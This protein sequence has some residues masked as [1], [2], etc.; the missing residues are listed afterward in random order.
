M[1]FDSFVRGI[2]GESNSSRPVTPWLYRKGHWPK[3]IIDNKRFISGHFPFANIFQELPHAHFLTFLRDPLEQVV[4]HYWQARRKITSDE[5]RAVKDVP[6]LVESN[7]SSTLEEI[8]VKQCAGEQSYIDNMQTRFLG[9]RHGIHSVEPYIAEDW[10]K[11]LQLA[12][13]RLANQF[14]FFGISDQMQLS[15]ELFCSTFNL[16]QVRIREK[17]INER[18]NYQSRDA[19]C[20]RVKKLI[21]EQNRYDVELYQFSKTLFKKRCGRYLSINA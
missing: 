3:E 17:R 5:A 6:S 14:G 7:A 2:V 4:S 12:K 21:H 8:L 15:L 9:S 20:E 16:Q 18:P 19:P 13:D 11:C 1:T 10:E